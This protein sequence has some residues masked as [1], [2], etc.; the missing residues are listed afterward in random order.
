MMMKWGCD[1]ADALGLPAWIEASAEG[2]LLYRTFGFYVYEEIT[3]GE[4]AGGV[5]MR[6]EPRVTAIRGGKA[7]PN[8]GM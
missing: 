4:L 6:R 7:A 5:N 1:V 2:N 8:G 3:V